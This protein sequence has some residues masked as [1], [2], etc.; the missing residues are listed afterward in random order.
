MLK[1]KTRL[2]KKKLK[3]DK[4]V[5]TYFQ[6]IDFYQKYQKQIIIGASA[7]LLTILLVVFYTN[8]K[9]AKEKQ[10]SAHLAAARFELAKMNYDIAIDSLE[11]IVEQYNGSKSTGIACFYLAST[12][13]QQKNY[14]SA[15]KYFEEFLDS[16]A[17][18]PTLSSSSMS[19]IA[20]CLEIKKEYKKAAEMYEEAVKKYPDVFNAS[21]HLMNA[22]RCYRLSGDKENARR[23]YERIVQ[24]FPNSGFK[25]D[26]EFYLAQLDV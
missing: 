26:A 13:F 23:T 6:A 12:Y 19:G 4:L 3:E 1:P 18:T 20:S 8:Q 15:Q 11:Q 17:S 16:Y 21:E 22:A 10:A 5:T 14:E 25:N 7:L 2:T 24:D 9:E